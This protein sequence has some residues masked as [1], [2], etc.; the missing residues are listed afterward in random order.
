MESKQGIFNSTLIIGVVALVAGS[1]LLLDHLGLLNAHAVF[2]F[3]PVV[4]VALGISGVMQKK[5]PAAAVGSGMLALYG[6][7]L[8]LI[9][10]GYLAWNQLWP[11]L[12]IGLGLLLMW[13][14]LRPASAPGNDSSMPQFNQDSVFASV[15]RKITSQVFESGK[16]SAVFG[17][18]EMD[19]SHA[20]MAADRATLDVSV[21]FGSL[22]MRVPD[23]WNV[24]VEATAVFG[25]SENRT[26]TPSPTENPKT[27]LVR[28]D[29]VFG[30]LEIKS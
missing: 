1:V 20:N 10:F 15:E 28:G 5:S 26:R 12:L 4:L 16:V 25:S 19:F 22:E 3:W 29:I 24:V 23:S 18:V 17:S 6:F 8:L 27:L 14:A 9:N 13:Q 30:S 11:I 7:L 2:R 21:V